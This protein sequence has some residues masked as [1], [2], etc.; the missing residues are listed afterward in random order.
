MTSVTKT[1][2]RVATPSRVRSLGLV[3]LVGGLL[4][5]FNVGKEAFGLS[6]GPAFMEDLLAWLMLL[7]LMGGPLG[8]LFLGAAGRRRTGRVGVVG[9]L[10][11]LCSYLTGSVLETMFG[12]ATS[13][14]GVFYAAGALLVGLGMLLLG[15]AVVL[16]RRLTGWRRFAPLSVGVYYAGMIPF[17]IVFFI[18]PNGTPSSTLLAFWGLTWMLLGYALFSETK[19]PLA[20]HADV[21]V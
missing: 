7:G 21:R 1:E 18:G 9:A 15:V 5:L 13:E 19:V 2:P 14:I 12:F 20:E 17:Q 3:C 10:L 11:G 4:W 8:L 16:E 6:L